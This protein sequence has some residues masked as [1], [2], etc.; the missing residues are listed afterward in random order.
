MARSSPSPEDLAEQA[1][2]GARI[3][4]F[5]ERRSLLK[6]D[7]ATA[8]GVDPSAITHIEAGTRQVSSARLTAIAKILGVSVL[9]L[10]DDDSALGDLAVAAR[11]STPTTDT[12][13]TPM[14]DRLLALSELS[15]VLTEGG[16]PPAAPVAAPA[17]SLARWHQ[18]SATLADWTLT[19]LGR[20][21]LCDGPDML[22]EIEDTLGIDVLCESHPN[23]PWGLSATLGDTRLT[24]INTAQ[25]QRKAMFT[26]A[27]E[28]GHL[29]ADAHSP[30]CITK[31][32]NANDDRERFANA[33]AANLLAPAAELQRRF[34][35]GQLNADTLVRAF[36]ELGMSWQALVYRLHNAG[37]VNA[38]GR[39]RLGQSVW[40]FAQQCQDAALRD[41]VQRDDRGPT[42]AYRPARLL[43]QRCAQGY[44]NGIVSIRPYAGLTL[45]DEDDA[46]DQLDDT[47]APAEDT[48]YVWA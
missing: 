24:M 9:A 21:Y 35:N 29:I 40:A 45:M 42:H 11:S 43:T 46:A 1:A 28:L 17:V 8:L 12:T 2:L 32:F 27:H 14:V 47:G 33:Y 34:G 10:L 39:D 7:L 44:L 20:R 25:D 48:A 38:A 19:Q 41:A 15:H 22:T 23:G 6:Q 30:M 4:H 5:R 3:R 13:D 16:L 36:L 37:I 18:D 31:T 26:L